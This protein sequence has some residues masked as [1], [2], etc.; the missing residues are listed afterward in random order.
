MNIQLDIGSKVRIRV[1]ETEKIYDGVILAMKKK[2]LK[3]RYETPSGKR[4]RWFQLKPAVAS[5]PA[6]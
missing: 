1:D 4:I 6:V 2:R 3:V 5:A